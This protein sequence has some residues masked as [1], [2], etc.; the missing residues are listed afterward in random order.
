MHIVL[1]YLNHPTCSPSAI[2][3]PALFG[4]EI[5]SLSASWVQNFTLDVP[6]TFNYNHGDSSVQ[7]VE[8]CN[9]TVT[10]THPG[11]DDRI[12]VE[13]WLPNNWNNRL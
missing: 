7:N 13:T 4:A 8:F 5:L 12:T 6:A 2:A 9:V 11:Y 1:H 10:Y 3:T